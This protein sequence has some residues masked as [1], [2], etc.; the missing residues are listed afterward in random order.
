VYSLLL[1]ELLDLLASLRALGQVGHMLRGDTDGLEVDVDVVTAGRK[2][3]LATIA[4]DI[5]NSITTTNTN[6]YT[7]NTDYPPRTNL[8]AIDSKI[9]NRQQT[10]I[11]AFGK[12]LKQQSGKRGSPCGHD[13]V[14]V[15]D[16][17]EGLDAG[18]LL[19]LLLGHGLLHLE[20][21][22]GDTSN[23]AL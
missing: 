8:R 14:V 1:E 9:R 13:V 18:A 16:L 12:Q 21:R 5:P 19:D 17:E 2:K 11:T 20:G 15:C 4:H 10:R 7:N 23:D 3:T 6:T 22:L